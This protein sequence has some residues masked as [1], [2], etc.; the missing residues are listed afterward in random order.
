MFNTGLVGCG[1]KMEMNLMKL[2]RVDQLLNVMG[3]KVEAS[4]KLSEASPSNPHESI[5]KIKI[6][7]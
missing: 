4:L 2:M 1:N 5:Y 6:I 7:F 3:F